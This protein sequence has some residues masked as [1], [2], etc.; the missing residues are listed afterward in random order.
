MSWPNNA[1]GD[2]FRRLERSGFDFAAEHV[3]DFNIDLVD[4]PPAPGLIAE[5]RRRYAEW[6]QIAPEDDYRGYIEIQVRAP[7][8]YEFVISMQR[9]LSE[10]AGPFGGVC[11]SWGVTQHRGKEQ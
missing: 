4:W 8:T 10:L 7:V 2:V 11:E 6:S 9:E 5:I 1:D 3:V